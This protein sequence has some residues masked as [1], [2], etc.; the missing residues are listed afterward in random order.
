[1]IP[2]VVGERTRKSPNRFRFGGAGVEG[3]TEKTVAHS[4]TVLENTIKDGDNPVG[5]MQ[6]SRVGILSSA[7]H[8]KFRYEFAGTIP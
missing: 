3:P 8:E 1:M 6:S 4:R 7:G 2:Q 5:E